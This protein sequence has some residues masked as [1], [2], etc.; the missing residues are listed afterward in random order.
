MSAL[1][2]ALTP[3]HPRSRGVYSAILALIPAMVGSSPLARGLRRL[4]DAVAVNRRIIP[5]RAGFTGPAR[6]RG[7]PTPDHPRSRGVY[8]SPSR[9]TKSA[10]G[11]SP[12]AR[13]LLE[14]HARLGGRAGIIPARA[15]FTRR[16]SRCG[17]A[18]GDHPRSRGV[19]FGPA[20]AG[21]FTGGSSPLARGLLPEDRLGGEPPGSS[22]LARGLPSSK[23]PHNSDPGII[24]ARAGFTPENASHRR[25][26]PDHPRSRGV[27]SPIRLRNRVQ[28]GS[29]PLARGLPTPATDP[30][31]PRK[32]HPRS[33]GVYEYDIPYTDLCL[34]IIPARAGFTAAIGS[35][36]S[37]AP[38]HPRSRGVY[39]HSLS[40]MVSIRGSS[41]LARGLQGR[42]R[43]KGWR[44][45][46]IPARAGFT[47]GSGSWSRPRADHPRS[48]G[49][50]AAEAALA[51]EAEGS[52]PLAR[53]LLRRRIISGSRSGI[54]PA[55]AGF[56]GARVAGPPQGQDHPRSRGVYRD[57]ASGS[58]RRDGSSPLAR[59]LLH[60]LQ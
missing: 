42:R 23:E 37:A 56:T 47:S 36:P 2:A 10:S 39:A 60:H 34:W 40:K 19:Y 51:D 20:S 26:A 25:T 30:D 57:S 50:Y 32:D 7:S 45:G 48:R 53:G 59:G 13:G 16:R 43:A 52:S 11:S 17:S 33:R 29:S 3:D 18:G 54:I 15:G 5:A 46:I 21:F 4:L 41:P 55:R 12:L 14:P 22:P 31:H 8:A 1:I 35:S 58:R 9:R 6:R 44:R 28:P 27:Y 24:P 38:D 49:V